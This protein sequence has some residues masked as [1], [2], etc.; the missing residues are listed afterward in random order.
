VRRA[1]TVAS[2]AASLLLPAEAR[3]TTQTASRS[4]VTAT[5]TFTGAFPEFK[6]L[7]LTIAQ[8]GVQVYD[9]P[10]VSK[11]CGTFCDPGAGSRTSVHVLDL[12]GNHNLEIVLDLYSGGAHCCGIEQVFNWSA[13]RGTY[14]KD[15]KNF[16]DPGAALRDIGH[17]GRIE[18]VSADDFFA[19]EFTDFADS[20]LP[21]QIWAFRAGAFHDVTR[22]YR[23]L[24][25]KDAARWLRA[26]KRDTANGDGVLAAWAADEYLLG[27]GNTAEVM[28]NQQQLA[29]N[30]TASYVRHLHRF[31]RRHGYI[32]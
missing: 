4:G 31:L 10:V 25:V 17:K 24:I 7:R 18:F 22:S 29:G 13:A 19:Y 5:F 8:A 20:G 6:N 32:R 14:V 2:I 27:R 9:Q 1:L 26:Y 11:L 23:A 28:L 16:G 15:E 21:L 12:A 3:A 30:I